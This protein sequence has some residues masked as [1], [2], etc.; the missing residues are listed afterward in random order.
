MESPPQDLI[1][2]SRMTGMRIDEALAGLLPGLNRSQA[3]KLVRRGH[4]RLEG[5]VLHRSHRRLGGGERLQ[6]Q[7]LAGAGEERPR[8]FHEDPSILVLEKPAGVLTHAAGPGSDWSLADLADRFWGPLSR[9]HGNRRPGI[10]H[11]LDR[12]TSGVIVVAR[13]DAAMRSLIQQFKERS[14]DKARRRRKVWTS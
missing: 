6:I 3:Q 5:R 7:D 4:V 10:V 13:T 12:G 14:V 9:A 2:P 8:S 11:R 1:I